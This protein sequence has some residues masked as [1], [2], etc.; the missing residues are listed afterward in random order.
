MLEPENNDELPPLVEGNRN[1]QENVQHC[2]IRNRHND[3]SG[4]PVR[5]QPRDRREF[6]FW[7]RSGRRYRRG[8]SCSGCWI[9]PY[10]PSQIDHPDKE[11]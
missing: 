2:R 6:R 5:R 3:S 11:N 7:A 1:G 10:G 8:G 4:L 9:I